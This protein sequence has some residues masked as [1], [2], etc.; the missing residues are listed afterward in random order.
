M[1]NNLVCEPYTYN[2]VVLGGDE[3][4]V[5]QAI[6]EYAPVNVSQYGTTDISYTDDED[7]VIDVSFTKA[8]YFKYAVN[9]TYTTKDG[10]Y[11][12][13][14]EKADVGELMIE[15]TDELDTGGTIP[16]EQ[17]QA[18]VYRAISFKRLKTASIQLK[19]ITN[20]GGQFIN[21]DLIPTFSEKPQLLYADITFN[22]A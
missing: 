14:V 6:G 11:L 20:V 15:L 18:A 1:D 17:V 5:A 4:E 2:V 9:V 16:L 13:D 19:D 12:T 8:T 22:K 21:E 7:N 10:T 3:E